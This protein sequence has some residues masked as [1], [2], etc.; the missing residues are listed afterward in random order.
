MQPLR[1][2]ALLV[3]A[4]WRGASSQEHGKVMGGPL[5]AL[6]VPSEIQESLKCSCWWKIL[7]DMQKHLLTAYIFSYLY[8][9]NSSILTENMGPDQKPR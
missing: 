8:T 3:R 6:F 5:V 7:P 1:K 9:Y 4:L 2:W